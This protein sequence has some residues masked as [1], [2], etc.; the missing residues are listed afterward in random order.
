MR[1]RHDAAFKRWFDHK[2]MVEDLLRGFAPPELAGALE[3]STLEPMPGEYAGDDRSG[4]GR[5]DAVWRVRF[6]GRGEDWLY[7]LVLLEFQSRIDRHMAARVLSYTAQMYLKLIRGARLPADGKLP[8]VLPIVIYNG[9][10]RWSAALEMAEAV[11]SAGPA[12]APYQPRQRHLLIDEHALRVEDL[13]V[14][15]V[16]SAQI[17]L[18][19][20][21]V[22]RIARTL[23]ELSELLPGS[24][25]ESLRRAF[26][27]LTVSMVSRSAAARS[28]PELASA[29]EAAEQTGGLS[30]MGSLLARRIDESIEAGVARG[31]TEGLERGLE[32]GVARGLE[33]GLE[34][35]VMRGLEQ[36]LEQERAMLARQAGRKFG[37]ETGARLAELLAGVADAERLAGI[38]DLVID[39]ADGAELLA[40][41][42]ETARTA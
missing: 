8:P 41:A 32:Q 7:L 16:V 19:Q 40:R 20:G 3:F 42:E 15:N 30:A 34:Q 9:E 2:R 11:A 24:E 14:G 18:E 4:S 21:S 13:P 12:L 26:A 5:A 28:H 27:E 37:A 22:P 17:A 6:R 23:R 1:D 10:R 39:C 35:G 25:H 38:G 31:R 29:L 33:Q 36:G